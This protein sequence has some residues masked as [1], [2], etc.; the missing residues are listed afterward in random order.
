MEQWHIVF[1]I[2]ALIY[3]LGNLVFIVFGSGEVQWWNDPASAPI[4][5][6]GKR[7][8][9]ISTISEAYNPNN[10]AL[11]EIKYSETS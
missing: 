2:S 7:S 5:M 4:E 10:M 9:Q 6:S 1:Y 11:K 3:F 8:Y